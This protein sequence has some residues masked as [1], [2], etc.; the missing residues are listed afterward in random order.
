MDYTAILEEIYHEVKPLV[1]EGHIA[2]YI[3]E[4]AN[5]SPNKFGM[6][7]QMIDGALFQIGDAAEKFSILFA[8][9]ELYRGGTGGHLFSQWRQA[10]RE[11]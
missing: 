6:A 7:V 8:V 9:D 10:A 3:P 4:L 1:G 2:D 5:I 11:W